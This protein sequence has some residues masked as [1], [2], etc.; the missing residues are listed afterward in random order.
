MNQD[1]ITNNQWFEHHYNSARYVILFAMDELRMNYKQAKVYAK[2][3]SCAGSAVW[4]ELDKEFSPQSLHE[5]ERQ[6]V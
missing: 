5:Y 4:D 2:K 6:Q 3:Q 1:T